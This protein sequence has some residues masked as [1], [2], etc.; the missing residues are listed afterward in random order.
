[1]VGFETKRGC[2]QTCY[3]CADPVA[4]GRQIRLRNPQDVAA[5]LEGLW[6]K[7]VSSFHTCDSEF[8]IPED[9]AL[10]VCKEMVKRKLGNRVQW[11]AYATPA[12]FSEELALWMKRAGCVGIDFGVDSGDERML[13]NLGRRHSLADIGEL[14]VR[15]H[16]HGFAF[17]FDLLLGGP[18]ENRKTIAKTIH[19]MKKLNPSRVGIS[20]GIRL[21][22][23]THFGTVLGN[24]MHSS[25]EGFF[26]EPSETMLKPLYYL[27]P[28]LG[29]DIQDY[30][31]GLV[32]GDNRFFFGGSEDIEEDYNYNDNS[33]LVQALQKGY[34][35]AF[36]DIL[37]RIEEGEETV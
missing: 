15:C 16:R 32:R 23:G 9:H 26:G 17:M 18:G 24:Q 6:E 31:G 12:P 30:I 10:D 5:E 14:A 13:Q 7:G 1:M 34:K 36:W 35:G 8:N 19:L 3:Y 33:R 2:D 25:K 27:S 11:Y 28:D 4:K 37:R 20:L 29:E 22:T 21:Y